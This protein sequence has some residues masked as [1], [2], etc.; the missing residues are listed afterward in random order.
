MKIELNKKILFIKLQ[1]GDKS[2]DIINNHPTI[3]ITI[4]KPNEVYNV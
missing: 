4:E 2:L 3:T 1:D